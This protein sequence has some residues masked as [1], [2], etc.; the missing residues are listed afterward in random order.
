VAVTLLALDGTAGAQPL[1]W[2]LLGGA[3]LLGLLLVPVAVNRW[4][5]RRG[6]GG[7]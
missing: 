6:Q 3:L 2:W 5:A 4:A 1:L 7:S